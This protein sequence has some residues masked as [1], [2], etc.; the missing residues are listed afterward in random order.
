MP[1]YEYAC[2]KCGETFEV[3]QRISEDPLTEHPE[4]GGPVHRLISH[5]SFVLKGSGWYKTDYADKP[6]DKS[7]NDAQKAGGDKSSPKSDSGGKQSG[8][9][10]KSSTGKSA[11]AD[12]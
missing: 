12:A 6:K 10:A 5:T 3:T 8:A 2:D 1:I 7:T 9:E 4:C 11:A